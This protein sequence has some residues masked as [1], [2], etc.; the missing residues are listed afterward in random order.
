MGH[1]SPK[2]LACKP[3]PAPK[4]ITFLKSDA[5]PFFH[6]YPLLAHAFI[7]RLFPE[8]AANSF[9][10]SLV[11]VAHVAVAAAAYFSDF[12]LLPSLSAAVRVSIFKNSPRVP[13]KAGIERGRRTRRR[14][15]G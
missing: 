13:K 11:V 1:A 10:S 12:S 2:R 4:A 8:K 9:F 14:W 7:S 5:A 6:F 15:R 3:T